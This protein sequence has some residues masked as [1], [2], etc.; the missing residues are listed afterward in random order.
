VGECTDQPNLKPIV[1]KSSP[2]SGLITEDVRRCLGYDG[3]FT[4]DNGAAL[5]EAAGQQ[6]RYV[7]GHIFDGRQLARIGLRSAVCG[8]RSA[9]EFFGCFFCAGEKWTSGT[10]M[11]ENQLR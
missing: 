11:A 8:L 9:G 7:L 10:E 2:H 4:R 6:R 5:T 3:F 1:P